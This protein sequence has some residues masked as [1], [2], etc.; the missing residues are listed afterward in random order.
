LVKPTKK[1]ELIMAI[2]LEE[3]RASIVKSGSE[4]K[5]SD[6]R[7]R[8]LGEK[9]EGLRKWRKKNDCARERKG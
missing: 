9:R 2:L 7:R 5:I 8:V 6:Q 4:E 3:Y 1:K